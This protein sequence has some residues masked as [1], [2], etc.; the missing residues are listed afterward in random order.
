MKYAPLDLW[1]NFVKASVENSPKQA[2][3]YDS[4]VSKIHKNVFQEDSGCLA[5]ARRGDS[6]QLWSR[7]ILKIISD[8]LY[9]ECNVTKYG[10]ARTTT[11]EP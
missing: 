1:L 10:N 11:S 3:S 6:S 2:Y 5:A 4:R 9:S 8:F 7:W